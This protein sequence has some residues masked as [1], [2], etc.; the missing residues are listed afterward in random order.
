MQIGTYTLGVG[1]LIALAVVILAI[2]GA[3]AVL[4][5]TAVVVFALIGALAVARLIP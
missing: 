4:P 2:L 5:F 3:V 1:G